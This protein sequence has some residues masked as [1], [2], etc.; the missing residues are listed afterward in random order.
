MQN[1][2]TSTSP[3]KGKEDSHTREPRLTQEA[4]DRRNR[5]R[6]THTTGIVHGAYIRPSASDLGNAGPPD[7]ETDT[8]RAWRHS[9]EPVD[10]EGILELTLSYYHMPTPADQNRAKSLVNRMAPALRN[11]FWRRVRAARNQY[12]DSSSEHES[13]EPPPLFSESG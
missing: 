2:T 12:T 5:D 1:T 3:S 10:H 9:V 8:E 11:E 4:E 13:N 6:D 7:L